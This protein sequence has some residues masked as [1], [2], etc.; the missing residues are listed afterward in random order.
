MKRFITH[1][2]VWFLLF[3]GGMILME[4]GAQLHPRLEVILF[5]KASQYGHTIFRIAEFENRNQKPDLL[6][7]GS[8]TCYRG[9]DPRPF[10][11]SGLD[12]F[13]LCSSKPVL[14]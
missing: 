3:L 8:S 11:S 12:A 6:T 7:L 9:I 13:N 2:F 10:A 14:L 5:A 4:L 1:L